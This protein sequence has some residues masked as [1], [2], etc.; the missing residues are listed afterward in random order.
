MS[1]DSAVIEAKRLYNWHARR[2][3]MPPAVEEEYLDDWMAMNWA[4]FDG[5]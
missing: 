2:K 3:P 4:W 1:Y 5:G